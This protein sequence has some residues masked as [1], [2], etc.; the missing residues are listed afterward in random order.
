MR[1]MKTKLCLAVLVSLLLTTT[2]YAVSNPTAEE[3]QQTILDF[4]DI[5]TETDVCGYLTL[6]SQRMTREAAVTAVIRSFGVYPA[7]EP[8]YV[9]TDELAQD[10]EYRPYIDYARRMGITQGI[11]GNRFDPKRLV[12]DWE[13]QTMLERAAGI[14]PKYSLVYDS[15][16]CKLLSADIQ[17]GLS[18]VPELLLEKFHNEGRSII[19]T[20]NPFERDGIRLPNRYIGMF[21]NEGDIW[22]AVTD[23]NHPFPDQ[24]ETVIHELGH[25]LGYRTRLLNR[26]SIP[27]ERDWLTSFYRYYSNENDDEFFADSFVVYVLW[28]EELKANAPTIYNHIESCLQLFARRYVT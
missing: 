24:D 3:L 9:W 20:T 11:G 12:T 15:P 27:N 6:D 1:K 25:Y 21:W 13:L 8:D 22:L 18:Q 4:H 7:N 10:K 23:D 26:Q 28:P 19:A 5:E 14:E 2:A 17:C 16:F